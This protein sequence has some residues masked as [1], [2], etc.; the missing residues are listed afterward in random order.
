MKKAQV[1]YGAKMPRT[2]LKGF[3]RQ[4]LLSRESTTTI[5]LLQGNST[6]SRNNNGFCLHGIQLSFLLLW[7]PLFFCVFY[8]LLV[9][10][11]S[12]S[13]ICIFKVEKELRHLGCKT[14][15]HDRTTGG[16]F[17]QP[18]PAFCSYTLFHI[19][20]QPFVSPQNSKGIPRRKRL[21]LVLNVVS[22]MIMKTQHIKIHGIQHRELYST[23]CSNL[24]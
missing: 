6:F 20:S 19:K 24:W 13:H 4:Q 15:V 7:F 14:C 2:P 18:H 22:L 21:S 23:F 16:S 12:H 11:L 17:P 5:I 9:N 10:F 8:F 3:H 1:Y